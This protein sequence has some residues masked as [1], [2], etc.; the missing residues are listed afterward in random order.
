MSNVVDLFRPVPFPSR[1][2]L[3]HDPSAQA[4]TLLRIGFVLLPLL[5]GIDKFAKVLQP[6]WPMYLAGAYNDIIPGTA[7]TAMYIVGGVE[8][9]AA[10]I[11]LVIPRFGSLLVAG[12]LGGIVASLIIVGG[13]G[14]IVLRDLALLVVA[15]AVSRLAW[16]QPTVRGDHD[17]TKSIGGGVAATNGSAAIQTP[18]GAA[19]RDRVGHR[20]A[21]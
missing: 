8:I 5:M 19:D 3:R 16:V 4:F 14:D 10:L 1:D 15:L 7:Q 20:V 6:D 11:V 2:R 12:W 18:N 21:G 9:A 13:Y 17:H